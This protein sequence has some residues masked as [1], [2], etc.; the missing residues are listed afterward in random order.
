MPDICLKIPRKVNWVCPCWRSTSHS[1]GGNAHILVGLVLFYLSFKFRVAD[2]VLVCRKLQPKNSR[3]ATFWC[4][5]AFASMK[6]KARNVSTFPSL[7]GKPILQFE[8]YIIYETWWFL[9]ASG[10]IWFPDVQQGPTDYYKKLC[11][12]PTFVRLFQSLNFSFRF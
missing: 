3:I 7:S 6:W 5:A 8:C 2:A 10:V 1:A 9:L 12:N 4:A 11:W